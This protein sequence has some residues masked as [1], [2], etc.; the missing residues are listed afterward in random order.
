VKNVS[1]ECWAISEAL[2]PSFSARILPRLLR[3]SSGAGEVVL[4]VFVSEAAGLAVCPLIFV[5]LLVAADFDTGSD[6]LF[7]LTK[8]ELY[9]S[10]ETA[11]HLQQIQDELF[12]AL[13]FDVVVVQGQKGG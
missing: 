3:F 7:C 13:L 5:L 10:G 6:L 1:V 11:H 9:N 12:V 2:R 4:V 8:K